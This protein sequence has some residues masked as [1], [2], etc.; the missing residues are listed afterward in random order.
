MM[1]IA[2]RVTQDIMIVG[3][4]RDHFIPYTMAGREISALKNV[5]SLTFRL[6]TDKEDACNYCNCG[7]VKLVFDTFMNWIMQIKQRDRRD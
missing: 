3:A 6:F 5:R 1:D 4:N 2:D 7:N